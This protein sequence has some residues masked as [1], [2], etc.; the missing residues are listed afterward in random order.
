[1]TKAEIGRSIDFIKVFLRNPTTVGAIAPSSKCLADAMTRDLNLGFDDA[2][3][4]LGPG[5]GALTRQI[6]EVIPGPHAY[7]GVELQEKF[8]TLLRHR[9]PGLQFVRGSAE[10]THQYCDAFQIAPVRA[11]ISGIPFTTLPNRVQRDIIQCLDNLMT[12]G[13][14]FRTFQYV[15][16]YPLPLAMKFRNEMRRTFGHHHRSKI[17]FKNLPPAYVLTWTR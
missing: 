1:M 12:P 14:V 16:A 8:V 2:I 17:V 11:I 6:R 15:H 4:E 5:T 9:F 3:I 7:L 13:C 10:L